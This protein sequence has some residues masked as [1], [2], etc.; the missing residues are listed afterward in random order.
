MKYHTTPQ[1]GIFSGDSTANQFVYI[2]NSFYKATDEGKEVR[3]VFCD[4]SMAQ[5]S[6][7]QIAK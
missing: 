5:R 4:I 6:A 7:L 1:S 2:Y 3:A